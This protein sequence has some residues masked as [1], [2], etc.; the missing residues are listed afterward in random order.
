[1]QL[2]ALY[3]NGQLIFDTRIQLRQNRL[4]MV[5][6][7]PDHE[8]IWSSPSPAI[9]TKASQPEGE[10]DTNLL[11]AQKLLGPEY[12]YVA[13]TKTD[14]ELLAEALSEKYL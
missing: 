6:I 10:Q 4:P 13:T 8:I 14:Q 1:M 9:F 2:T 7:I 11:Q 5:V 3:D 12:H